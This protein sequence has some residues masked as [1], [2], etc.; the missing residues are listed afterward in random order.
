MIDL[1]PGYH[2]LV[3]GASSGIG[4]S[5]ALAL[6]SAGAVVWAT[7][8]RAVEL[9]RLADEAPAGAIR[10]LPADLADRRQ[11]KALVEAV[12]RGGRLDVLVHG[13]TSYLA[14]PVTDLDADAF[15]DLLAVNLVAPHALTRPLLPLLAARRGQVIFI[16][17][18]VSQAAGSG[19]P[20]YASSKNALRAYADVLRGEVN[21]RGVRVVSLH[22]GRVATRLQE[23]LH[24]GE[25]RAYHPER[26]IQPT[27]V[28]DLVLTLVT[29]PAGVEVTDLSLRPMLPPLAEGP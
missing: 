1:L 22:L 11:V 29:L 26:M 8:R 27:E 18:S 10:P 21:P 24:A 28:A 23:R 6:A 5:I 2:A 14:A 16:N 3:T 12:G 17:S 19:P 20:A 25:G 9:R 4:R 7:A 15:D 13:A